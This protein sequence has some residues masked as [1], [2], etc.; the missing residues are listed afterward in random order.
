MGV[1]FLADVSSAQDAHHETH[2]P[3]YRSHLIHCRNNSMPVDPAQTQCGLAAHGS[4]AVSV[5]CQGD[6]RAWFI[7]GE[8]LR[9]SQVD[10]VSAFISPKHG[11]QR[12]PYTTANHRCLLKKKTVTFAFAS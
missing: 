6:C 11:R 1:I 7:N 4:K 2:I 12:T 3:I 8:V 10:I 9:S 5:P